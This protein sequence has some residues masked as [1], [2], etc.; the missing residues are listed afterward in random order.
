MAGKFFSNQ[1]TANGCKIYLMKLTH[2][3]RIKP[4][5]EQVAIMDDWLELLRRHFNYALGQRFDWLRRTRC[6]IDR[7]SLVSE[8]IGDIPDQFPGYNFQA[9]E[10][11]Q[12]KELFPVY[13]EIHAEVQQQN[14]KRVDRAWDR[15]IKPDKSGKKAGRPKF[16]KKGEMRSFT[17]PRINCPLAGVNKI[18]AGILTLSKIGSMPVIMHRPFP[19]GF[20]LKT[21]TIVKKADGWYIAVSLEDD[22]VPS[23]K[24]IDKIKSAVGVDLGLKFF[25]VTSEGETVEVQQQYR[26]TQK[27]LPGQQQRL[28]RKEPGSKKSQKQKEKISRI[29]QRI[30]RK[31]EIF[32]YSV[33]HQLVKSYDL[34]AVEDLN[35]KGLAKTRLAKSIYDVAWSKL[36]KILEAVALRSGVHFVKVSPHNTTVNCSRCGTK[37]PKTLSVR[38]HE[39]SK[40]NL[41]MDRDENA[42]INVLH[43]AL[44]AVG[45]TVAAYRRLSGYTPGEV[46]IPDCEVGKLSL[47]S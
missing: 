15:W 8:P 37:V 21:A 30:G 42:A 26:K 3:Y 6:Q 10:L 9:G 25:L 38:L 39:C 44:T 29:H 35:I 32:H 11:K 17:F 1:P 4:S 13:K 41:E 28:A 31:R 7:C 2:I 47:Y 46:G 16:K 33:A 43:K 18:E 40:C 19:D 36:L 22:S 27:H 34:I 45:L 14:L 24:P 20:E 12:T 23:P 5:T